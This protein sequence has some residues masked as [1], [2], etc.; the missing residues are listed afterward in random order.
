MG[1]GK[2]IDYSGFAVIGKSIVYSGFAVVG[3]SIDYSGFAV[4]LIKAEILQ[5]NFQMLKVRI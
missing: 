4:I 2:S 5:L 3:K 1:L